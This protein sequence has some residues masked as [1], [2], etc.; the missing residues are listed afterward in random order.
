MSMATE[1]FIEAH[2]PRTGRVTGRVPDQSPAD[3]A[4]AVLV[5]RDNFAA[6]STLPFR[7]RAAHLRAVRDLMLDRT[8]QL[9]DVI[10]SE[11]GKLP[12][13]AVLTELV[14]TAELIDHYAKHGEKILAPEKVRPGTLVHKKAVRTFAPLGVVGVISP[15]NY[16]FTLTMTPVIS[17][18]F[19]G[20]TVVFKPS[21]VTPLVGLEIAKLFAD[22]G[23]YSGIVSAVTGGGATGD[24]LVR[25]GVDK[26]CFTG[27]VRTGKMV[28]AAASETLTPVVLE[29][30]GK[31]P[32]IVCDDA[33]LD[34][35]VGGALWGAFSNSGQTCMAVERVYVDESIYDRFVDDVVTRTRQIRQ[36]SDAR[37]DIGSMTFEKQLDI[38]ERHVAD[39]VAKGA[40][41]LTGG[42]RVAG[43]DGLWYE[44]TVLVDVDHTM[45][46]M[47][48]ETFGPVLPIMSVTGDEQAIKLANDSI[49]GLNSS[50][51]TT[52]S[53]RGRRI[54]DRIDAGNVC[55]ND[56]I[57]SYAVVGLPFGGV[58]QS[59]IGKTHG[60]EGLREFSQSKSI[61]F[62]RFNMKREAWWYPLPRGLDSQLTRIM[63][64]RY[65][66]G[67]VN[68]LKA[69]LP[70]RRR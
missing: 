53:D 5:A 48:E 26:I 57:V 59:G 65:R 41:V 70:H 24:A 44:P 18:L 38:V 60:V 25:S 45:D 46:I 61:L 12:A 10:C 7:E 64:L 49:Y 62:D 9:V 51:W 8:E 36:G 13:E 6:W 11:T 29:L 21:E 16:P 54:A 55:V 40:K 15:W 35:A 37:D 63:R 20:N 28:M 33:N 56:T 14:A 22:V 43:R 58:K 23:S 47:T 50:V 52:D 69:L 66:S 67:F 27:S 2:D 17:A 4:A 39:A 68:K 31:D 32:M 1:P 42:R 30:G 19:A 34:R 3:V